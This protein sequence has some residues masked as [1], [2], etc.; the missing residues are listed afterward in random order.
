MKKFKDTMKNIGESVQLTQ[1][2]KTAMQARITEY[3]SY[4]PNRRSF[5]V[6]SL[7]ITWVSHRVS[8][9]LV[10]LALVL[11]SGAGVTYASTDALPGDTLY[12]VKEMREEIAESFIL[13]QTKKAEYAI[14]RTHKRL[15]EIEA[16]AARGT[17][18]GEVEV[19]ATLKF[20]ESAQHAQENIALVDEK[21][22]DEAAALRVALA[23]GV[24]TRV[25]TLALRATELAEGDNDARTRV[26]V[27]LQAQ[28]TPEHDEAVLA[29]ARAPKAAMLETAQEETFGDFS[30][31]DE[32]TNSFGVLTEVLP[33]ASDI[34][35]PPA[36]IATLVQILNKQTEVLK[37][38]QGSIKIKKTHE[39]VKRV[40]EHVVEVKKEI[41][42]AIRA[43]DHVLAESLV[44][45]S[46]RLV[47]E[48]LVSL[49][50][51]V[52]TVG[53]R[54]IEP[55]GMEEPLILEEE[56]EE[57]FVEGASEVKTLPNTEG[58][59]ERSR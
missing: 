1:R 34:R 52:E 41:S 21:N 2:E 46:L 27:A 57:P 39:E 22:P 26:A 16:L 18:E 31:E 8:A 9:V 56:I 7:R 29:M 25:G 30:K 42:Q 33:K 55:E 53:E 13:D 12:P 58:S 4:K 38:E 51:N 19:L 37:E 49:E 5:S 47:H 45:D 36:K 11:T 10:I 3:M 23:V 28:S 17:L 40:L 54:F 50:V 20:E 24:E 15:Q 48:T 44:K 32:S 35:T 6:E 59:L 14:E 43:G